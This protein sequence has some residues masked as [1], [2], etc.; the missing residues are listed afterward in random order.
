MQGMRPVVEIMYEDFMTLAA[1]QV[2]NQAAKHRYMSG[3]QLKV[4]VV[5]R[6]QGGAGWSPGA[7]HAQQLEAWF[8]HIPG[9]KVVFASTPEDVRGLLW[10]SIYDDNPV[11]FF[12]HRT[13]YGIKERGAGEDRAD[14]DRQGARP[15]RGRGRDR[16]S[17]PGGSC[18]RR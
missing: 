8:V 10:S 6:T 2:V 4:P 3:G 5:F 11:V 16:R 15:P 13:L 1:E 18:T 12:E 14:P 17:P 7:Q 9:L